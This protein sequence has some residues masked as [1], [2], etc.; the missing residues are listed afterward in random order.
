[1]QVGYF[2]VGIGLGADPEVVGLTARTAEQ[3]GFHSI[4][5]PEHVV[6][7]DQYTSKYPYSADG[8]L[9]MPTTQIDILDPFAALTYAAAQT[10][11]IRLGTGICLVPERNPVVT[12]KEVAS[13]DKLS[14]G[15]FDFG[16]GVG[17]LAEEFTAVGVP[18]ERRAQRT[19]EYLK[20]MKM[21]WTE[22]ES[23]FSG[24]FCSFPKVRSYPKPV[25]SPHPPIIFGGESKPALRRVGE[26]GDGWFGVNVTPASTKEHIERMQGYAEA[27]GRDHSQF[28]Y[29]V[30]TGIGMPISL[31]EVKQ[32]RDLGVH[33]IIVGGFPE[34]ADTVKG[35]I[36]KL[37]E[38]I[39][40]PAANL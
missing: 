12:A 18:W 6:L 20:V 33:Q 2:A 17:W 7:L 4:W 10:S 22:E 11:T 35:D 15:R 19:R 27:A 26:V 28:Q 34:S 25:Q 36:E 8:R 23:E 37:A 31:D 16:V 13:L 40:V 5:A 30:S 3:A 39:V 1:M 29:S 38:Q 24:E 9:P 32:F 21:L 14:G